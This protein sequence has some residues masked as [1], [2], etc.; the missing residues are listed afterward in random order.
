VLVSQLEKF[1]IF[2]ATGY[3]WCSTEYF[4][5][6]YPALVKIG[7]AFHFDVKASRVQP[8]VCV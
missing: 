1:G 6:V 8:Y 5:S 4:V 2:V 3:W 7:I